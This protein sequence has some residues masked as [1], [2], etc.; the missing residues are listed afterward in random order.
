MSL[1]CHWLI[2]KLWRK[3]IFENYKVFVVAVSDWLHRTKGCIFSHQ[4]VLKT[5]KCGNLWHISDESWAELSW[6]Q[7][8]DL[9]LRHSISDNCNQQTIR[10]HDE[11][12]TLQASALYSCNLSLYVWYG[13][14]QA[15]KMSEIWFYQQLLFALPPP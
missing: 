15:I 11:K 4:I 2:E 14:I 10:N 7:H 8:V 12:Q 6:S 5:I 1:I 13:V 9:A 3:N